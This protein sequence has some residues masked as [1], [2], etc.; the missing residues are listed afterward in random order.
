MIRLFVGA[1]ECVNL[2]RE[3]SILQHGGNSAV[4]KEMKKGGILEKK[5]KR[6]VEKRKMRQLSKV[7]TEIGK[8]SRHARAKWISSSNKE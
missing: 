6:Q 7:R 2:Q 1:R 3:D 4:E 5:W 8:T